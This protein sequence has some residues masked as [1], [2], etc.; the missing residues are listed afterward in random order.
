MGYVVSK[1]SLLRVLILAVAPNLPCD[2]HHTKETHRSLTSG[3]SYRVF[4]PS[5]RF[6]VG[7]FKTSPTRWAL[8]IVISSD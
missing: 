6:L 3:R 4:I 7:E 2:T 5:F 1:P 8:M